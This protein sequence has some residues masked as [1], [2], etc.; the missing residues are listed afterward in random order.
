MPMSLF[1]A[2][3][4]SARALLLLS[5]AAATAA[6]A[7]AQSAAPSPPPP[8]RLG[9]P[10]AG[11]DLSITYEGLRTAHTFNTGP[12]WLQGAAVELHA[13]LYHGLGVVGDINR[14]HVGT[15]N[16]AMVAPLGLVTIQFGMRYTVGVPNRFLPKI[17]SK[18]ASRSTLF[19]QGM[20]GEADGFRSVFSTGSGPSSVGNGTTPSANSLA[21]QAGAGLD[22]F[23]HKKLSF[24]VI[25]VDYL[26][27]GLPNGAANV[28]NNVRLGAGIVY[29]K[30]PE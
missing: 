27:T 22:V 1:T 25:Q 20:A 6:S 28:Q 2:S 10:K 17:A 12:Y 30:V 4:S 3:R 8:A 9:P 24:R 16:R 23:W 7:L 5:A 13:P 15:D 14:L 19:V 26:R 18:F 29:R 11:F 21:V